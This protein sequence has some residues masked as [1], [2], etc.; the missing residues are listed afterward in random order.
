MGKHLLVCK[1]CYEK[2]A[3]EIEGLKSLS[4]KESGTDK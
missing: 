4:K 2:L 3:K 1:V